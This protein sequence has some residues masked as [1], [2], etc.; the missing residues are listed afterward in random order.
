MLFVSQ[1]HA[2]S[3]IILTNTP[4]PFSIQSALPEFLLLSTEKRTVQIYD[5]KYSM[6]LMY[7][8]AS[9]AVFLVILNFCIPGTGT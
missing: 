2:G 1:V 6:D 4:M 3:T 7:Y 5:V 8:F 9:L